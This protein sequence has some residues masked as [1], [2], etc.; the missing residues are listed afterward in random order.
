V[1]P[2]PDAVDR[3]LGALGRQDWDALAATLA[4]D[5]HRTG[6]YGDVRVGREAYRSFLAKV[7]P[8]LEDYTL[9]ILRRTSNGGVVAVELA[10][11]ITEPDRHRLRTEEVVV[12][13]VDGSDRIERI[14]VFTQDSTRTL[15]DLPA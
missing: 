13:D 2:A 14:R 11:T 7:V 6:P 15:Q 12:F 3:Y 9:E 4:E 1:S 8:E 10:E 5:V